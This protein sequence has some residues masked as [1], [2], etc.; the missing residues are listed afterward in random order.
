VLEALEHDDFPSKWLFSG[1]PANQRQQTPDVT[2]Y[3]RFIGR[4]SGESTWWMSNASDHAASGALAAL[5]DR[6]E[7]RGCLDLSEVDEFVQAL[8]F[9]EVDVS[10]LYEQLDTRGIDLRD[11][12]SRRD[13]PVTPVDDAALATVTTDTLQLFLN[14]IGRH[15]LLTPDEEIE[16]AKRIERG[17]LAAKDR[18]INANL[19]L[20]VSIAKK[21]QGSELTLLDL[22]Q[23]GILGLIRA[24]EKFD[25]R[26]GYRFSTYATWWIRQAVERGMDAKAR[27]I[28]LPINLVRSQRKVARAEN[29]LALKLDRAPTDAEIAEEAGIQVDEL[30]ALRDAARTVTSLDRPLGEEDDAAFG[31][32][33]PSDAPAPEDVVHIS[34][35]EEMLRR[36]LGELP[37]RERTVVEMRY[38]IAGSDPTP[39]R[40]IGRQ[41]GI[42]PE[43]VRQIESKALGR[44][45]RMR[46]LD[47]LRQAA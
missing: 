26:R 44:L 33:L 11:D 25:W 22:I 36:A 35:R 8:E 34:L 37:E 42:T 4:R 27:T 40:E 20:V 19:R 5:I 41:L 12:C 24:V 45:G 47:A 38:G 7:E 39:L 23:E 43:R 46:E 32:L 31:D 29:A 6:G 10:A 21:Y 13:A 28:K 30:L 3:A 16:L 2:R 1:F 14:E 17:D 15:R 18:M 9:E